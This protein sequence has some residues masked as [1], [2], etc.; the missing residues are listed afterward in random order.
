M[1]QPLEQI[2]HNKEI[3]EILQASEQIQTKLLITGTHLENKFGQTINEIKEKKIK[4][5][6]SIKIL[7]NNFDDFSISKYFSEYTKQIKNFSKI[8]T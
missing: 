5:I 6:E 8:Q 2:L 1:L 4:N 7:K 3:I